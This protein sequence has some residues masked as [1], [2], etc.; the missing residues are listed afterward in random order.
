[1]I[2]LLLAQVATL[3]PVLPP[4]ARVALFSYSDY[5]K[6][7]LKKGWQGDVQWD[8]TVGTNGRVT[9]CKIIQS[10]GHQILDDA[11]CRIVTER[12]RFNPAQDATGNPVE[13][14]FQSHISWRIA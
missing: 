10:S 12:A 5:P 7:A 8:V 14:H 6:E 2:L 3:P 4:P 11:T 9:A 1:M 13:A